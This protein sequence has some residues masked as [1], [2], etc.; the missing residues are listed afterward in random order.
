MGGV[1]KAT[2]KFQ[3]KH[4]KH[5]LE[6]R[7]K[8]KAHNQK[9]HGRRGN[10]SDDEK[11]ALAL[12]KDEQKLM[13]SSKEEVFKDMSVQKFFDGGFELPKIDKKL[14]GSKEEE[15]AEDEG[16]SSDEDMEA[17]MGDLAEKDPEFYKYLQENDKDLLEFN[18]SNPLDGISG[19]DDDDEEAEQEEEVGGKGNKSKPANTKDEQLE[20]N[21]ALLKKLKGQ[22]TNKPNIKSIRNICSAFKAA[23]N[24]N[25]EGAA[26]TYKFSVMDEKVFQEL[27]FTVLKDLPEA[28]QK[29]TPYKLSKNART[30]PS[31]STVTRLSSV[32]KAHAPSLI[33]LLQD[34]TNTETAVLVLHS[35]Y[36]LLPYFLSYRKLLKELIQSIVYIWSTTKDVETQI[37]TF[38][39]L[40]NSSREFKKSILG[41]VLKTTYSTFVKS[42]RKTNIRTMPLINFQKNSSAELFGV[43]PVLGY[44]IGFEYIR[45]LAIHLRNSINGSTKKPSKTN[46]AEAYKIVYNWQFCHSLDFWSRVLSFQCNPEKENGK[47]SSLRQLIYP[48]IQVTL[49]VIRLIP[50]AQF[51][52]LRFYLIRSLIRLSQNAGVYIPIYPLLSET[53]SST[54]FTKAPKK[55]STLAAFDFDNNIKCNQAYLGTRIYQDGLAEQVVELLAEFY[56]LYAKSVSFPE[57]TTPT[58][59]SLRRYM[60]TSK[61]IKFNKMLTILI[62]KLKQNN[63]FIIQKR[64]KIDFGPTNRVE[65]ERFLNELP[66]ESTPLGAYV[67][68][69]REVKEEK[70]RILRE[71]LEE[72]DQKSQE[73]DI[74]L[75]DAVAS[76]RDDD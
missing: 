46:S 7:K 63:D 64:S 6:H 32:M 71:S 75:S 2:K 34:I 23:V 66:W 59:I 37:A 69:Q 68:I 33:T 14:K 20:L 38:A 35:T 72:E 48:L 54:A 19:D 39:F 56:V 61:N 3:S 1:S 44:Q 17:D 21:H 45:Q 18:G 41:L 53:L 55:H 15:S 42:C 57:L 29:L 49:G 28:I 26:E 65:V 16:S 70:A 13:K 5:T 22:L 31:N 4:L 76:D 11:R 24:V 40:N 52:P 47:E 36:Q 62:D 51:F 9:I 60:K 43:D 8:V 58:I 27:M 50:T 10:K 25:Q 30:L 74:E 67:V 73:E 12:T